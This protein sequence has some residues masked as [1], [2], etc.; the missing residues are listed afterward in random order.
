M[1]TYVEQPLS[2]AKEAWIP[3]SSSALKTIGFL[4]V[5]QV[6]ILVKGVPAQESRTGTRLVSPAKGLKKKK[7]TPLGQGP[8]T[9]NL[10]S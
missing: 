1:L 9:L 6:A 7:R 4:W 5:T 2:F 10:V 8:R 3:T